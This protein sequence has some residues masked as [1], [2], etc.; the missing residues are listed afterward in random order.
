MEWMLV[1][2]LSD[3]N[4]IVVKIGYYNYLVGNLIRD[5]KF[6][7]RYLEFKKS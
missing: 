6:K 4:T 1:N 7:V 2:V 3:I 5:W